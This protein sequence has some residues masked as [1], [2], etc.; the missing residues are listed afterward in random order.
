M[1]QRLQVTGKEYNV[2]LFRLSLFLLAL[3]LLLQGN[4]EG[5]VLQSYLIH[6]QRVV[7]YQRLLI[8]WIAASHFCSSD[9]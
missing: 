3:C 6:A 2:L 5:G 4:G 1:S 9:L 7:G 8:C